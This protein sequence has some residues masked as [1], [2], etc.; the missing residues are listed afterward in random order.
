MTDEHGEIRAL[1]SEVDQLRQEQEK[2]R[3]HREH[4][5]GIIARR[6]AELAGSE[7]KYRELVENANSVIVRWNSSGSITFANGYSERLFGYERGELLGKPVTVILAKEGLAP[8]SLAKAIVADPRAF[9]THENENVTKDGRRLW[10]SW[11]NH[12]IMDEDEP[13]PVITS[14]GTDRTA[15]HEVEKDVQVHRELLRQLAAQLARAEQRERQR[16]AT[17]L[18]EDL[19]QRLVAA[20]MKL[21]GTKLLTA[22]DEISRSR[23]EVE[24]ILGEAIE[25]TRNIALELSPPLLFVMGL[26]DAVKWLTSRFQV[27][28][29]HQTSL[30]VTGDVRRLNQDLEVLL[31]QAVKE[32][33]NN[34]ARHAAADQ[35]TVTINYGADRIAITVA[36]NGKGFDPA[37]VQS[38][39][40]DRVGLLNIRERMG[41]QQG[42]MEIDSHPGQGSRIAISAPV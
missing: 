31:F 11:S 7:R 29:G 33:L 15:E 39:D 19:A 32:L 16:I 22:P 41:Y 8:H 35:L 14:V 18:H 2:L 24:V 1:R 4:L 36:D 27:E 3:R 17:D 6:T 37:T 21:A 30:E 38:S 23:D 9:E 12:V 20:K 10:L 42:T 5:E 26:A 25:S 13:N 34:V 40:G 28:Y